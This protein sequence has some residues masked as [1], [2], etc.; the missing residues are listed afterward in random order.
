MVR[1]TKPTKV[2]RE[3]EEMHSIF[4]LKMVEDKIISCVCSIFPPSG[5]YDLRPYSEWISQA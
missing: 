1:Q 3:K 2:D 5:Y 4:Y